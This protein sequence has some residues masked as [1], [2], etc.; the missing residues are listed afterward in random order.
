M[1][2]LANFFKKPILNKEPPENWTDA[3]RLKAERWALLETITPDEIQRE[4][5]TLFFGMRDIWIEQFNNEDLDASQPKGLLE[6]F[7]PHIMIG[8]FIFTLIIIIWRT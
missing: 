2:K 3:M 5:P 4:H 8:G 6:L 1:G 7:M